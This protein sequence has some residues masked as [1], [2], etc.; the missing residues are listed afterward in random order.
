MKKVDPQAFLEELLQEQHELSAIEK[1]AQQH[2]A[3]DLPEQEQYYRDLIPLSKPA[4][5]EQYAFEVDLDLCSGC[6][7]CVTACHNLNGLAEEETWRNVG[8]VLGGNEDEPVQQ[9]VTTACHH[10]VEPACMHG[11]P[12]NAYEKDEDTG[13]VKHLDDQCIGCQ[14][15]ILKCPYEVPKYNKERG[16]VRKCDMCSDRL[17]VGEAPACVQACPTEAIRIVLVDKNKIVDGT[18][19]GSLVPGAPESSYT[20]PTTTYKKKDALPNNTLPGD[21]YNVKPQHAHPPLVIMLVLTQLSVGAFCVNLVLQN[22]ISNEIVKSMEVVYAV[23][24]FVLGIIAIHSALFHLGRPLYAFRAFLGLK[25]SWLSREI[26]VFG[27][28]AGAAMIYAMLSALPLPAIKERFTAPQFLYNDTLLLAAGIAVAISGIIGVIC[29]VMI[30]GDCRKDIWRESITGIKFFGSMIITGLSTIIFISLIAAMFMDSIDAILLMSAYG[31]K[32]CL[33]LLVCT[34][35]K[36]IWEASI[37]RHLRDHSHTVHKRSAILMIRDLSTIT[38][39]RF[40]AGLL[41]GIVIPLFIMLQYA[42]D[43]SATV[44][45]ILAGVS[46]IFTLLGEFAERYLFFS[47]AVSDRMPGNIS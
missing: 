41:G 39:L 4:S 36:L 31:E 2:D 22:F 17:S 43:T 5:G 37:F 30:Y 11:C 25:K 23:S 10:C 46:F 45:C 29:S 8:I 35:A 6:K 38:Q 18:Q 19:A 14:Y 44:I 3:G 33:I 16:I 27:A 9:H 13:I 7:A 32:L 21:F 1:Y 20:Q 15:C 24:A 42:S 28:F 34:V 47:A 26:V 40:A 12:V